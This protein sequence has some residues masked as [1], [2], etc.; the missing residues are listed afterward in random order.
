MNFGAQLSGNQNR[1]LLNEHERFWMSYFKTIGMRFV[2]W[3]LV[4]LNNFFSLYFGSYFYYSS[5]RNYKWI[6]KGRRK[7]IFFCTDGRWILTASSYA[8]SLTKKGFYS[9]RFYRPRCQ[10]PGTC[11]VSFLLSVMSVIP[12]A[13]ASWIVMMASRLLQSAS[14]QSPQS[15]FTSNLLGPWG[16]P[17]SS[18]FVSTLSMS[19]MVDC[20]L[21]PIVRERF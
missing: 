7:T 4:Y 10:V 20:R 12:Q 16:I 1:K 5:W 9:C 2:R 13:V 18:W 11:S 3:T 17:C 21:C 15:N 14:E 8:D 19:V 6:F